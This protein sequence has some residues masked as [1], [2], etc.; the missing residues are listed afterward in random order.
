MLRRYRNSIG[1]F[2]NQIKLLNR[3]GIDLVEDIDSGDVYSVHMEDV[4]DESTAEHCPT[5]KA[6]VNL[7]VTLLD[8]DAE[9]HEK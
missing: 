5:I 3:D 6:R 1:N 8:G 4:C 9:R 2:V 7:P